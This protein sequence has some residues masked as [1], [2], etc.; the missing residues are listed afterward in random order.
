[1]KYWLISV[2]LIAVLVF[3]FTGQA[4]TNQEPLHNQ[5]NQWIQELSKQDQRFTPLTRATYDEQELKP[6]KQW[7]ITFQTEGIVQGYMVVQQYEEK[8]YTLLEYGLGQTPLFDRSVVSNFLSNEEE[9]ILRYYAGLE[10]VWAT[11]KGV[12]DAKSG[13][14]YSSQAAGHEHEGIM[15]SVG[16]DVGL[17]SAFHKTAGNCLCWIKPDARIDSQAE[18]M[19]EIK[20]KEINLI[21]DLFD[22]TVKAPYTVMGYHQW[23]NELFL[24]IEDYGSRF[25]PY[26]YA[27][28][29][30]KL[31][32]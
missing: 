25:I 5:I 22:S 4:L 20:K 9:P 15:T 8:D 10:S 7:L 26:S 3:P 29:I 11:E 19:K 1:M 27:T 6:S 17:E 16:K 2:T 14:K 23:K 24:E 30:G 28:T 18:F 13:E 12:Y 21:A 32:E 31:T